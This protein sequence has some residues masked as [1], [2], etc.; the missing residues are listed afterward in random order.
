MWGDPT[1]PPPPPLQPIPWVTS[2]IGTS[3]HTIHLTFHKT[4]PGAIEVERYN[5]ADGSTFP[6]PFLVLDSQV[7]DEIGLEADKPY[8]YRARY[9]TPGPWSADAPEHGTEGRTLT[10]DTAFYR[11]QFD[12]AAPNWANRCLVQRFQA[13]ALSKSGDTVSLTLRA[14][15][16]GL[17]IQR[18]YSSQADPTAGADPYDSVDYREAFQFNPPLIFDTIKFLP[19][20]LYK[21]DHSKPLLIAVDFS[22]S[23]DS[24]IMYKDVGPQV[25][26]AYFKLQGP[27]QPGEDPKARKRNRTGYTRTPADITQGRV[28]LI[29]RIEVR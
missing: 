12:L 3:A 26:V 8:K 15:P 16:G 18:I 27:L 4:E 7:D 14:G 2:A 5:P 21:V 9:D 6:F 11:G 29:E 25:A 10:L 28:Y 20:I 13:G 19:P 22:A 1:I 23:P 24:V 17:S